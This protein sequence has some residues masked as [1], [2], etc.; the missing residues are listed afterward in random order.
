MRL[1]INSKNNQKKCVISLRVR[2]KAVLLHPLS[3]RKPGGEPGAG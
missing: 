2:E 3:E 1:K